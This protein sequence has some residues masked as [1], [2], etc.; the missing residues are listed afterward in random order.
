MSTESDLFLAALALG[1][2]VIEE[3]P[4]DMTLAGILGTWGA[5]AYVTPEEVEA[6][7]RVEKYIRAEW[8]RCNGIR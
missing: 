6:V 3:F 2:M 7:R 1:K 8:R 4:K 5:Q